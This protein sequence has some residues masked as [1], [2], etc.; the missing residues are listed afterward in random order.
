MSSIKKRT[1]YSVFISAQG[2]V[3]KTRD[4]ILVRY[5]VQG[6]RTEGRVEHAVFCTPHCMY[7]HVHDTYVGTYVHDA[8]VGTYVHS[9]VPAY[10]RNTQ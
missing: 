9:S 8:Y 1:S 4:T 10:E 2:T 6:R 5:S 3:L 7:V